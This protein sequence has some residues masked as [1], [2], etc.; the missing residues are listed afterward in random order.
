[1]PS[2]FLVEIEIDTGSLASDKVEDLRKAEAVQARELA[3]LGH[4]VTLWRIPER[5]ANCGI[6]RAADREHLSQIL[7]TLPLRPYMKVRIQDLEQHPSDPRPHEGRPSESSRSRTWDLPSLEPLQLTGR[8]FRTHIRRWQLDPLPALSLG[9]R[10]RR[11]LPLRDPAEVQRLVG[12]APVVAGLDVDVTALLSG[13][14]KTEAD[15]LVF[16][17]VAAAASGTV[18]THSGAHGLHMCSSLPPDARIAIDVGA[19]TRQPRV[20]ALP[21]GAEGI[22]IRSVARLTLTA[23]AGT[24]G[25]EAG[26]LLGR[27]VAHMEE[28]QELQK[29]EA[30]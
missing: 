30:P 20:R 3:R 16:K 21:D 25:E 12:T 15:I 28:R 18:V 14:S 26:I 1:M 5:W 22:Q 13:A 27:L 11:E 6:W 9:R 2:E 10:G 29:K 23:A 7:G 8:S 4:L 24:S 19:V 17:T